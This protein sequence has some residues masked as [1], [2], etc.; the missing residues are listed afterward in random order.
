MKGPGQLCAGGEGARA[1]L[2]TRGRGQGSSVRKR[3]GPALLYAREEGGQ[4]S[5]LRESH[6]VHKM[7]RPGQLCVEMKG[8][9][10]LCAGDE[11]ARVA[12]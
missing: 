4:V 12:L 2:C 9:G 3:K 5:S 7:K 6:S 11:G 10:Q 1:A 8:P